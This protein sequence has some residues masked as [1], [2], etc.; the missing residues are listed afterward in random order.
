M[1][2][3]FIQ[4][5]SFPLLLTLA[6]AGCASEQPK[7]GARNIDS[8]RA[9]SDTVAAIPGAVQLAR[10]DSLERLDPEREAR[11]AIARGDLRFLAVCG[12]ACIPAGVSRDSLPPSDSLAIRED[13]VHKIPGTSD[14]LGPGVMRLNSAAGTYAARYNRLIL[15]HRRA[16]RAS[17]SAT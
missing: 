3:H 4:M 15:V 10:A 16:R 6:A 8:P 11:I 7:L 1:D 9:D 2:T 17:R 14:A 12:Y 13:S 5:R